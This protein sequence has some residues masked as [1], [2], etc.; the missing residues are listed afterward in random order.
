M[1]KLLILMLAYALVSTTG[2]LA[3][4][5]Q[6]EQWRQ[7]ISDEELARQLQEEEEEQDKQRPLNSNSSL[8]D[9]EVMEGL[10]VALQQLHQRNEALEQELLFREQDDKKNQ[11]TFFYKLLEA[12]EKASEGQKTKSPVLCFICKKIIKQEII[13][14]KPWYQRYSSQ[15]ICGSTGLIIGC[16]A[17]YGYFKWFNQPLMLRNN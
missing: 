11:H 3:M 2:L 14:N 7:G 4:E 1:K 16:L 5:Q 6:E 13:A 10:K 9:N 12:E 8:G 17:T 15:L